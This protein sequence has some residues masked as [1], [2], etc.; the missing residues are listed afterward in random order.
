MEDLSLLLAQFGPAHRALERSVV[1][2]GPPGLRL[3]FYAGV[4][5]DVRERLKQFARW[6]RREIRF[7]HPVQVTVVPHA[8]V[9]GHDGAAAWGVFLIPPD[10][11]VPGDV[12][13]IY[14]AGGAVE[15]LE[16]HYQVAPSESTRKLMHNLAHE[17]VHYEQW[18]DG[19]TVCERGV[20]R[21][22]AALVRAYRLEWDTEQ[23]R[24]HRGLREPTQTRLL[25]SSA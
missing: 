15:V 7:R 23:R 20:N 13:R 8:L 11:Y 4:R 21:R 17:I 24:G 22:A 9:M 18:R 12:T 19:R 2:T 3:R 25:G 6:L 10:D 1:L 14:L 16:W 5:A